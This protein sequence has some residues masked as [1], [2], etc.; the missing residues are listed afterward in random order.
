[1]L[2]IKMHSQNPINVQI[3]G[4]CS[5]ISGIYTYINLLNGKNNYSKDFV[6]DGN[7]VTV[8][9]SFDGTNW[10]LHNGTISD[11]GFINLTIP[12]TLNP[13]T[14]NWQASNC[15]NGSMI[16]NEMLHLEK[17]ENDQIFIYPNPSYE[18]IIIQNEFNDYNIINYKIMD[19][20][21]NKIKTG[22]CNFNEKI[23]I[24]ELSSGNYFIEIKILNGNS[25]IKKF[26]KK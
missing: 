7:S 21:G 2:I 6:I 24:D 15:V 10:V 4:N 3:T 20:V 26:V 23:N 19:L 25:F 9:V 16:I 8:Y 22:F 17:F 12:N 1:M 18:Y 11:T 5:N 14:N 13:P